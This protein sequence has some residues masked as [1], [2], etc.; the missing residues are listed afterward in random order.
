MLEKLNKPHLKI[1]GRYKNGI[2][3]N[4]KSKYRNDLIT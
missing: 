3:Q 1:Q 4:T 2:P